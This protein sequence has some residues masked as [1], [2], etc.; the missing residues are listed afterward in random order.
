MNISK[1]QRSLYAQFRIGILPLEIEVGRF[2][3]IELN[4]RLCKLCNLDVV[5][6]EI[7]FLCDCPKYSEYRNTLFQIAIISL[8]TF[9]NTDS[10]DKFVY[11]I[12]NHERAVIDFVYKAFRLRQGC[13]IYE[14]DS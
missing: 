11:L 4:L 6:D 13:I 1:Y 12:A 3:N 2:H 10:L 9:M 7:H 8:P 5:E 14:P